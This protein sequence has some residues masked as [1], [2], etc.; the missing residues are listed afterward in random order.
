MIAEVLSLQAVREPFGSST[1]RRQFLFERFQLVF[2]L[3]HQTGKVKHVYLFGSFAAAIPWPN[4]VDVFVIMTADF[5]LKGSKE[6]TAQRLDSHRL[7]N[8]I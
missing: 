7:S 1:P 5:T 8:T 4:N 2:D 3:L 6:G